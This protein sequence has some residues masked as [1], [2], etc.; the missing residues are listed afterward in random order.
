ML[1]KNNNK[2]NAKPPWT[3]SKIQF[4][5]VKKENVYIVFISILTFRIEY[6]MAQQN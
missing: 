3:Q 6:I 1:L 2:T 5:S 4:S